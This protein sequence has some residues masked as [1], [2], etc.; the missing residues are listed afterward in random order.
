MGMKTRDT[1]AL[2]AMIALTPTVAMADDFASGSLIV[3]MDTTHQDMG[4]LEAYGLVYELLRQGVPVRWVI[5]AG[6]AAGGVDLTAAG[7]DLRSGAP[8][9]SHDYRGGPWVIDA[10]DAEAALPVIEAWQ[11]KNPTT[12]VHQSTVAF[13]RRGRPAA[14]TPYRAARLS[15][16]DRAESDIGGYAD[17]L[18]E[19]GVGCTPEQLD[20]LLHDLD[21]AR[22]RSDAA[23]GRPVAE[24]RHGSARAHLQDD[25]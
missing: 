13:T 19:R 22:A 4:M 3:P 24:S 25:T 9:P 14:Q 16:G 12:A 5:K 11:A 1:L 6:K 23:G 10:A 17:P 7:T 18:A 2:A 21:G 20:A 8:I 15:T